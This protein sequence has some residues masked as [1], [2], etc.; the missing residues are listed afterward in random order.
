MAARAARAGR[1]RRALHGARATRSHRRSTQTPAS[2]ATVRTLCE[3]LDCL[4]L[5]IELAAARTRAFTPDDLL[6]RLDDRFRL[7]TAGARTASPRQQTLRAVIDWSYDLLFDDERRVFERVSLFAGHFGVVAAED[8]LCRRRRSTRTTSPSCWLAWSTGPWSPH[9]DSSRG[10]DFRLLQTLAQYGRERLERSG[11]AAATRARHASYVA[12]ARRGPRRAPRGGRGQ[13]VPAVVGS[14]LDDIR[15]A[16]EWAVEVGRRRH[17]VRHRGR[18][19]VV[20]EHGRS[21]RRH[22]AVDHGGPGARRADAAEPADP[23]ARVGWARR[24]SCTTASVRWRTAP[25]AVARARALGDDSA[26]A[27]ATMLHG[28]AISDFFHRTEAATDLAEESR[29]TF[30]SVGD[31]WSLR[32]GHPPRAARSPWRTPTTTPRSRSCGTP[33]RSSAT[34]ATRG[35]EVSRCATSPTSQRRAATTTKPRTRC[36]RRSSAGVPWEPS[37]VSSGLTL[38]LANVYALEGRTD[39][40]DAWFD[41]GDRGR[42]APALRADTCPGV[43]P[44]RRRTAT[45]RPTRRSRA[46]ATAPRSRSPS[47]AG[48]PPD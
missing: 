2:R 24:A 48:C 16:M 38:R 30:A 8:G 6:S 5:A 28:S 20:L 12:N 33:P 47:I 15:F 29:R 14:W 23:R 10:V 32:H 9:G 11:D 31:G 46:T 3:R 4:P 18:A 27:L 19:R 39:E 42:R 25:K 37:R 22:L 26:L 44:A 36:G 45:S 21:H 40:A 17:R 7:L 41:G 34:S 43:Q 1:C 35:V 13:L